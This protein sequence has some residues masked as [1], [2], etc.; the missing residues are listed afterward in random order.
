M[1]NR[2]EFTA[3]LSAGTTSAAALCGQ[4]GGLPM[5]ELKLLVS[6]TEAFEES[7]TEDDEIGD[8]YHSACDKRCAKF[9]N[10]WL[11][12]VAVFVILGPVLLV[13][14]RV[15]SDN[16]VTT[17]ELWHERAPKEII[18]YP[19]S[20]ATLAFMIGYYRQQRL[21]ASIL[22]DI[23]FGLVF[24]GTLTS[25]YIATT[26]WEKAP[27]D[28][29]Q[30]GTISNMAQSVVSPQG[31]LWTTSLALAS[32]LLT[33]SMYTFWTY[34][35][36]YPLISYHTNPLASSVLEL[37]LERRL[38]T[39]WTLVPN[40]GF[41]LAAMVPSLSDTHGLQ[42]ILTCVHNV[43]AP[44][45]MLFCMIMETVQLGYGEN[46]FQYFF[47]SEPSNPVYGPLTTYQRLRV[48]LLLEAWTAGIIFVGVQG[49]LAFRTNKRWWVALVSYY[50]EVI[51]IVLA[52]SLPAAAAL[53]MRMWTAMETGNV[54][55]ETAQA[56]P[57]IMSA[58]I[59]TTL[60]K[61]IAENAGGK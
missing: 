29:R 48:V 25:T 37:K 12:A 44:L 51:G 58:N 33:A 24:C 41:V 56:I 20:D 43:T 2:E 52:F 31:R 19:I 50:G 9:S 61:M 53:D 47:S 45:S 13:A 14:W 28:F 5:N 38:R 46:A 23:C 60:A 4:K 35:C 16:A 10:L 57:F 6:E 11:L 22:V 40:V 49:Y 34:R 21:Q 59:N 55:E 18:S 54:M 15:Q 42:V 32:I 1:Q 26:D 8:L 7:E 39:A 17:S 30:K 36:W 3:L 27:K